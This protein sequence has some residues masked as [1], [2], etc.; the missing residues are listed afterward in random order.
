MRFANLLNKQSTTTTHTIKRFMVEKVFFF[1]KRVKQ[2]IKKLG[3]VFL[4]FR[5]SR[6]DKL[7]KIS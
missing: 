1:C 4:S 6:N 2:Y 7:G 5:N 3:V